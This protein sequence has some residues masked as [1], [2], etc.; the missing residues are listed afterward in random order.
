MLFYTNNIKSFDVF[1]EMKFY[2]YSYWGGFLENT[3]PTVCVHFFVT[4]FENVFQESVTLSNNMDECDILLEAVFAE[5]TKLFDK[6]WKYSFLFSGENRLNA[7]WQHYT[8]VLGSEYSHDNVINV[9]LVI[10]YIYTNHML[11]K[12]FV[13]EKLSFIPPKNICAIISNGNTKERN[14]FLNKLDRKIHVDYLGNYKN[15]APRIGG[16]WNTQYFRDRIKEYKFVITMENSRG[17]TY[18]TEKITHG[19]LSGNI[20]IYWGATCVTDYFNEK[21][22]IHVEE[23]TDDI[24]DKKI[25]KIIQLCNDPIEYSKI[26]SEPIL[27]NDKLFRSFEDIVYDVRKLLFSPK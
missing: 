22:F 8:C 26:V 19:F 3:D 18:I 27:V 15:N 11:E 23:M 10:P 12:M 1:Y 25:D 21:R 9:P 6:K 5:T 7:F 13:P 14:A 17:E 24:I 2:A 16:G 4:L 20:P